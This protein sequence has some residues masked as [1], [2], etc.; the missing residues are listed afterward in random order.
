[1]RFFKKSS[2][3]I[4]TIFIAIVFLFQACDDDNNNRPTG[5]DFSNVPEPYNLA[6][7]DTSYVKEG[8]VEIYII[9]E[10]ICPSGVE[11]FCTVTPRDRI[12]VKYTG[13]IFDDGTVFE[14]T[15]ANGNDQPAIITNLT[16]NATQQQAAQIEGFRRGLLGMKVGEK[17]VI[18]VPPS[19][20]Y[21]N[22]RPGVNGIDLRDKTLRYDVELINLY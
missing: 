11:D 17:R 18:I 1:M 2:L 3:V 12:A 16:P 6:N 8:D 21:D 10:G 20:G 9:E 13:R 14:S 15:F 5:H 19:L 22:S 7:A 4:F